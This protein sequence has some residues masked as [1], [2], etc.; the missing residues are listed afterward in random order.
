MSG[1]PWRCWRHRAWTLWRSMQVGVL[2][3]LADLLSL[4]VLVAWVGLAKEQANIPRLLPG[5]LIM[6]VGNKYFAFEDRSPAV[7]RQGSLFVLVEMGAFLLN[8]LVY[9]LLV[10][11][12]PLHYLLA[13]ML[14]TFLVYVGFSFPLWTFIFRKTVAEEVARDGTTPAPEPAVSPEVEAPPAPGIE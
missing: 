13:G 14:G 1:N 11:L 4:Y 9:H 8:L 2:A 12:T 7:V 10:T 5:L 3:G 6:F